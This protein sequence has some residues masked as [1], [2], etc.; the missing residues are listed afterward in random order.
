[1][2]LSLQRTFVTI[3]QACGTWVHRGACGVTCAHILCMGVSSS[4]ELASMRN[5]Q[6][7]AD[8]AVM[9]KIEQLHKS[10]TWEDW[11]VSELAM[12]WTGKVRV[13][14]GLSSAWKMVFCSLARSI[15]VPLHAPAENPGICVCS[16]VGG[17]VTTAVPLLQ[18]H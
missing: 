11:C 5:M 16:A 17:E 14:I 15:P 10:K 2:I 13:I 3:A 9:P 7:L 1:M 8:A 12:A 18:V 6:A 4:F